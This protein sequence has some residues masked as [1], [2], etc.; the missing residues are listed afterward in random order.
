[1]R[2]FEELRNEKKEEN[3]IQ[4]HKWQKEKWRLSGNKGIKTHKAIAEWE[5]RFVQV[6]KMW[7]TVLASPT[8]H[9]ILNKPLNLYFLKTASLKY[10]LHL[11]PC[12]HLKY[13]I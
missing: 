13:T 11:V 2:A 9:E 7:I 10:N 3:E 1:M 6:G 8:S 12:T 5:K 4:I